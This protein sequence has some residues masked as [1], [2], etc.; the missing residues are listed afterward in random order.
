[1]G[2]REQLADHGVALVEG[3]GKVVAPNTVEV[4]GREI[5]ARSVILATGSVSAQLP[6][7]AR[8]CPA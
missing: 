6:A 8:I 2:T 7:R 3:R 1:M 4:E 5:D